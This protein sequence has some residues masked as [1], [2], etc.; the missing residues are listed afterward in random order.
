MTTSAKIEQILTATKKAYDNDDPTA[1][2][3]ALRE[4]EAFATS[5]RQEEKERIGYELSKWFLDD[6][7]T[8]VEDAIE[9]ITGIYPEQAKLNN[10][11]RSQQNNKKGK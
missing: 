1:W 8:T 9:K 5:I 6:E 4:L 7:H 11:L 2:G 3:W 10:Y